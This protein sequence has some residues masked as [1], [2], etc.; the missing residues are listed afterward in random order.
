MYE[1]WLS[2]LKAGDS[3]DTTGPWNVFDLMALSWAASPEA[4]TGTPWVIHV[5]SK[6]C[7]VVLRSCPGE[8]A[9]V[10]SDIGKWDH[11]AAL[12]SEKESSDHPQSNEKSVDGDKGLSPELD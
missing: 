5:E 9:N 3:S 4:V 11:G 1:L 10:S 7:A 2:W 12:M 8:T 6:C